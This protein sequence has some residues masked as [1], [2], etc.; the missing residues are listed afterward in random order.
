[1]IKRNL[2]TVFFTCIVL[3]IPMLAGIFLWDRLPE[4]IVTTFGVNGE[5]NGFSSKAFT[6]YGMPLCM[7]GMHLLLVFVIGLDPKNKR[8][9]DKIYTLVLWVVPVIA[10]CVLFCVYA[11]ALG[12]SI[13]IY[14]FMMFLFGVLFIILGNYMP[15]MR[16]S[17]TVGIRLPWTLE[18]EENWNRTHRLGG[19][20]F[21]G[22]GLVTFGLAFVPYRWLFAVVTAVMVLIPTVYSVYLHKKGI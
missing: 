7:L 17:Y 16:Q 20:V 19:W 11:Y 9:S 10:L 4:E 1:M 8:I 13:D 12:V 6:V 21:M 14:V 3:L 18:S 5:E 15:K 22:G 2:K